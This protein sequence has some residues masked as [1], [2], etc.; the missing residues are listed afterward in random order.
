M[1]DYNRN[2]TGSSRKRSSWGSRNL[3]EFL[4]SL[5]RDITNK[6]SE[7]DVTTVITKYIRENHLMSKKRKIKTKTV[8]ACD[9]RLRLLFERREISIVKLPDLVAKLFNEKQRLSSS[10]EMG[11]QVVQKPAIVRDDIK[12][13][14]LRKSLVQELAKSFETFES[15]VVGGFV[16]IMNPYQLVQ[17]TGVKEG[18]PVDGHL[19]QVTNYSYHLEDVTFSLLSD[20]DFSQE[21][22]EEL[23]QRIKNGFVKR[24]TVVDMEE[25]VR[26]LHEDV[27]KHS[28]LLHEVPEVVA[29]ELEPERVNDDKKTENDFIEPNNDASFE[30]HQCDKEQELSDTT[31]SSNQETLL[32]GENQPT[33][34]ASAGD[35][36][37]NGEVLQHPANGTTQ[38]KCSTSEAEVIVLEA[39]PNPIEI[40]QLSDD[41]DD[42]V[43]DKNNRDDKHCDPTKV[44]WF[45]ELPK[46][47]THGPFSIT[48]LKKWNE[49]EYFTE[50]PDFK[51]W[52]RGESAESA[53]SLTKLLSYIKT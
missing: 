28:R 23:H 45:Y 46:G 21:E 16:R 20:D 40:I 34:T 8:V 15:K 19:L 11:E 2:V 22:C 3:I 39:Q 43:K 26:S 32:D 51:V 25:K 52:M 50:I 49:D 33:L 6:I 10:D 38:N 41:D 1:D 27:T 4:E 12:I 17:V 42:A 37:L 18:N 7:N 14:Y 5:G 35:K 29:E 53:V 47:Q 44:L 36:D 48:A 30:A 31:V 24:F 9:E 13:L